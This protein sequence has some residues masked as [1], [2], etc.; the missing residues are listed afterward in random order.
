[1]IIKITNS[2]I[3]LLE[4]SFIKKETIK[5][6]LNNNPFAI[7]KIYIEENIVKGY[8][9]Y[10]DI[11]DRIEIN[12]IEVDKNYRNNKIGTKLLENLIKENKDITLEVKITNEI[13]IKKAREDDLR[14]HR[15]KRAREIRA[16]SWEIY[17]LT[18][19]RKT[20]NFKKRAWQKPLLWYNK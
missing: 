18:R 3:Y 1:M 4:D 13:A 14:A 15:E 16:R 17:E 12:N 20:K 2:N 7:I 19:S 8:I 10:S 11:Y 5:H 6:E 9:Y